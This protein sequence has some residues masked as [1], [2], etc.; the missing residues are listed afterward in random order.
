MMKNEQQRLQTSL[1]NWYDSHGRTLPWRDRNGLGDPYKV[2]LSEVMLQQTTVATV[3][4]YF[5]E[6]IRRWP[7][8]VALAGAE[9]DDVL[10]AWQDRKSVV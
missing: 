9:L 4:P 2:W 8:L 10:H 6:F 7:S 3:Q 1:L 5:T